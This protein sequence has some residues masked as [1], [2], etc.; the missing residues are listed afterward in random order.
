[1]QTQR[2]I[3]N[4]PGRNVAAVANAGQEEHV[5]NVKGDY[6]IEDST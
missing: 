2:I 1:M 3:E 5:E 4:V 6:K